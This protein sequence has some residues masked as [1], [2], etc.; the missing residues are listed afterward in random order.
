MR[1]K[2]QHLASTGLTESMSADELEE[3]EKGED[4]EKQ[5]GGRAGGRPDRSVGRPVTPPYSNFG[6]QID[7]NRFFRARS[8]TTYV[9]LRKINDKSHT[10]FSSE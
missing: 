5:E 9:L 8:R 4:Q 2:T 7:N 1:I 3:K 6:R 10:S